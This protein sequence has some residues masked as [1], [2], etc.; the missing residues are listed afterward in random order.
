MYVCLCNG[1]TDRDVKNAVAAG[2]QGVSNVYESLGAPPQ[3]AKCTVHIREIIRNGRIA[4]I[5]PRVME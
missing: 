3:C 2:A 1:F 4:G 5:S